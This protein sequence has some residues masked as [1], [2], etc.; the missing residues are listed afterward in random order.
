MP[1]VCRVQKS[2]DETLRV[3]WNDL[4]Y[5]EHVPIGKGTFS[6]V[7]RGKLYETIVA[8][9]EFKNRNPQVDCNS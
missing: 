6:N 8:I 7:Y 1:D 2:F 9:K 5:E 3:D 4:V